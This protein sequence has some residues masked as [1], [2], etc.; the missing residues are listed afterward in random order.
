MQGLH[1]QLLSDQSLMPCCLTS[2]VRTLPLQSRLDSK[3]CIPKKVQL[4]KFIG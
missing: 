1:V 4:A 2:K 3:N